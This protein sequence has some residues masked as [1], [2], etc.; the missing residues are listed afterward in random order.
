VSEGML[1]NDEMEVCL[2]DI[3]IDT[4]LG[5]RIWP[6]KTQIEKPISEM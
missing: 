4:Y 3:A 5:Y 2:A 6:I 1:G